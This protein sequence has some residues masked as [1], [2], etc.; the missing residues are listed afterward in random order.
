MQL[1]VSAFYIGATGLLALYLGYLVVAM[2]R[3]AK[4]GVGDGGNK[5]LQLR[6]RAHANLLEYAPIV[7]LLFIG[8]ESMQLSPWILH[9]FGVA[10]IVARIA[11]PWGLIVGRGAVHSG[12]FWGTLITW[13]LL[14]ALALITM[15]LAIIRWV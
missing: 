11:H 10:W 3:K 13:I 15:L 6:I 1:T 2:R 9:L 5:D 7:L 8:A 14:A 12:R 4:I